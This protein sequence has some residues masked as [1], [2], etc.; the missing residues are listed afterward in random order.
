M[1]AN[2]I[3]TAVLLNGAEIVGRFVEEN[4]DT[5]IIYKP[6]LV[7]PQQQG[8]A[9]VPGISMTGVEPNGDFQFAKHSV[10]Y[11]IE[12]Q[13][14]IASSWQ[15]VTSGIEMPTGADMQGLVK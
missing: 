11:V 15:K 9:F 5:I 4:E 7:S 10:L 1:K 3:V 6:R 14:Q 8:L 2:S 13:E 12:T